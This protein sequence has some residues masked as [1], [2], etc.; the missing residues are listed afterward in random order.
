MLQ[1]PADD[2]PRERL[3]RVGPDVLTDEELIAIILGTGSRRG[4]ALSTA[5]EL[6]RELGDLR[7][8]AAASVDELAKIRG[9]GHVKAARVKAALALA[10]RF[11]ERRFV[12]GDSLGTPEQVHQRFLRRIVNLEEEVFWAI[13]VDPK[14]RVLQE[15]E[16]A[17]GDRRSVVISPSHVF[18]RVIRESPAGVFFVHNHPS[19]DPSPSDDDHALTTKL[20]QGGRILGIQVV[21]H[22]VVAE[23]GYFSFRQESGILDSPSTLD[24]LPPCA[25]PP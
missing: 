20:A 19:G 18:A 25:F 14:H 21:D 11:G 8:V 1:R 10:A 2:R 23:E 6:V 12:R 16:L 17:R 22:L 7:R 24:R 13:A 9:V 5:A 15:L 3:E 4:D